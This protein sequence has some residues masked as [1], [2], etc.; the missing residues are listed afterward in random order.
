MPYS[1]FFCSKSH[2]LIFILIENRKTKHASL[3]AFQ[4]FDISCSQTKQVVPRH[5]SSPVHRTVIYETRF[6]KQY[7]SKNKLVIYDTTLK[8]LGVTRYPVRISETTSSQPLA[9]GKEIQVWTSF[10]LE[11]QSN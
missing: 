1:S 6:C 2:I 8:F 3:R 11:A 5:I 10:V 4:V 9:A 7:W